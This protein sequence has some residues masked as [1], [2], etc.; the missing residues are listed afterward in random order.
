MSAVVGERNSPDSTVDETTPNVQPTES[1]DQKINSD[2]ENDKSEN[3]TITP[4]D[5]Q[6]PSNE[7]KSA[8]P[9]DEVELEDVQLGDEDSKVNSDDLN[10]DQNEELERP[11]SSEVEQTKQK[12]EQSVIDD[13]KKEERNDDR[14]NTTSAEAVTLTTQSSRPQLSELGRT[15]TIL[16][17]DETP[18]EVFHRLRKG[19][20]DESLSNKE[21]VD[22][23]FNVLVGGPF[24]LESRFIIESSE[25]IVRML[26]LT[27]DCSPK[28]QAEIWSVFVAI[29]RKSFRNLEACTRVGLISICL[30][31]LPNAN[32]IISDLLIELL[33]VLTNYSITVKETKHFLR[34]LHAQDGV[35]RKNSSKL[36]NVMQEMPKRDGA[37]VFFSFPGK[38]GAG[39]ALPPLAKWPYQNGWTFSTWF[40]MDPLNSVN[41]EKEKPFLFYLGTTKGLGYTCYFMGSCLV[42]C[43]VRGSGKEMTRCIKFELQPRKWHHISLSFVY[44]RWAK[45]EIHCFVDGQ[46]V[47]S[48]ESSWF[49]STNE[50]FDRCFIGCGPEMEASQ[51]FC[52]QLGA[53]YM[54]A[55]AISPA[56]AN[57][58]YCLGPRYQSYYKHD[59]ESELPEDYKRHLFDG[60]LNSNLVFAYC[61]KNCHGQLCLFPNTKLTSTYFIQVPHAVMRDSVEVITTHSIHNSL[62]SVGGIQMLLPLFAQIDM[63]HADKETGTVDYKICSRL[64]SVISL[65][66]S[67][68]T[69]AQQQLYHS[70]GF[71]IIS[72]VLS[73]ASPLHLKA[74]VLEA[75][76]N[77]TRFL[78]TCPVGAPL[79]KQ[80]FEQILLA[81]QLWVRASAEIQVYLYEY[82]SNELFDQV[83]YLLYVRR[84]PTIIQLMHAI[85]TYYWVTPPRLPSTYAVRQRDENEGLRGQ[86]V[87]RIRMA[88]LHLINKLM[89]TQVPGYEEKE[90]KRDEEFQCIFNFI[91]NVNEDDNLYDVLTFTMRQ[92]SDNPAIMVPAFDK[93]KG[94]CVIFKI[95]TSANE[96]IRIP[97]L[98]ILGYFMCR[99]TVKRKNE[100][101]NDLNLLHLL[102]DRL[103]TNSNAL[104][105]ATYN[106]LFE[107]LV[108]RIT[109]NVLFVRHDDLPAESTRFE[110]PSL[111]KVIANLI[112]QSEI[113]DDLMAV[114]KA[115]LE[116]MIRYCRDSRENRRIILQMSVWQEWLI[117]LAHVFP[118]TDAENEITDLVYELFGILL[119]HAIRL[120]Y[121][122]WRVWVD[123]LA[124]A[125][126]KISWEKSR[127]RTRQTQFE[128]EQTESITPNDEASQGS[129]EKAESGKSRTKTPMKSKPSGNAPYRT[130]EFVWSRVHI[131][132]LDDLLTYIEK[133]VETWSDS[134]TAIVDY[135]NNNEN[136]IFVSNTVHVLSQLSDSLIMACGGLLPLLAAA[137][138][139]NS[140]LEIQDATHQDITIREAVGFLT[141]FVELA[142]IFIFISG[143]SFNE[144]EQ[145][146]N[147]PSGGILRQALRLVSTMAVRNI[148]ACRVSLQE[149]GF[150]DTTARHKEKFAAIIEFIS[151]AMESKD[152]SK[153]IS[154]VDRLLQEIDI[155]RLKGIIYRDMEEIRQA[156]FLAL[157]VVYL[158]SVLMVSRYRDILEPP[159]SPSPFFDTN[160]DS[161]AR[162]VSVDSST[163]KTKTSPE[164]QLPQ[165]E[166]KANGVQKSSVEENQKAGSYLPTNEHNSTRPNGTNNDAENNTISSIRFEESVGA[167]PEE[168]KYDEEHLPTI[169]DVKQLDT[170][171]RRTYLTEK[172][173]QA[174]ESVAPLL[175]EIMSDFRSFLQ[176][177]LLGTHGQE[178][179]NDVKVMQTLKNQQ[180]SVIELVMLLCSQEWQTSLQKHA[181]LAFIEL[182]NEGR[183]MAH[184]TRDHILRVANEADFILNRLRAE[185]VGKHEKF[186]SEKD[187]QLLLRRSDSQ[188]SDH[189]ILS[190]RRRNF[191][192]ADKLLE[193]MRNILISPTGVWSDDEKES[194]R[195]WRLDQWEDDSR[196]RKRFVP[197]AYGSTHSDATLKRKVE[198]T[199]KDETSEDDREKMLKELAHQ[200]MST[201][202]KGTQLN[203]ELV[204]ESEINEETEPREPRQERALYSTNGQLIAGIAA[205][206]G[207]ISIAVTE[208]YFDADK[209][210][211]DYKKLDS[212]CLKYCDYL[213]GRWMFHEIR[214]I[215]L[216]RY[217]LQ[218]VALELFLASRTAIMFAFPNQEIVKK[219]VEYLPRVGVGVKYGLP[220]NRKT[221][222][223]LPRQLFKHSD[224]PEKWQ[225]REI[226]NFDYLMFLNTIAG[227][228][229]NDLNQYPIFPWVLSNYESDSLD[230]SEAS[231]F[232][233]LSK[234]VGALSEARRKNFQERFNN[235]DDESVPAFHYGTHYS[236][237]SFT[238]N[239][240]FRLEPFTTYFLNLQ[241]GKF[242]HP[243]RLFNSM[244]EAWDGCQR[245]SHNVKELVPELFYLPEMFYNQNGYDLGKRTD[246]TIVSDV[247]L[248][249]WAKSPEH[250]VALHRQALESD[251][252]SCQLNQW[253]DLIF[254]Y[255]QRGPEAVRATNVF[256]YLTYEGAVNLDSIEPPSLR[257]SIE[258][259]ILNFGQTPVQLMTDPHPPRHSIMNLTP[260][261]FQTF[262]DDLC[263]LM[264]FISN[265]A[266]VHISANTYPQLQTPTVVSISQ[267][268]VFALNRWNCN[269]NQ[270][271]SQP[272]SALGSSIT[273]EKQ[274]ETNP[275]ADLP[276]TV[277]PLLAV[278][279]PSQPPPKRHLGDAFD[280]K[281]YVNWSNFVTT[282]DSRSIIACGYPDYSFRVIDTENA[283]VRQAVYGHGDVVT[284]LARSESNLYSDCYV[285]SGSLDCTVVL[286]HFNNQNQMIIGE[287]NT[288]GETPSPRAIL[289]GHDAEITAICVSA[290]HG[291]VISG[292]KDGT[293]LMHTTM[294]DL[295]RRV[296][297]PDLAKLKTK[298]DDCLPSITNILFNREGFM[299]IFYGRDCIA[300]I[301]TAGRQLSKPVRLTNE[302]IL[303]AALSRDGEN[304]VIGTDQGAI[305]VYKFFPMQKLYTFPKTDSAI[306]CIAISTNQRMILG[307]LESGAVV[308]FNVD[309]NKWHY[310][311]SKRRY[312][313]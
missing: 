213:H 28:L 306:R 159:T 179:M 243:D 18:D 302:Q 259:Q 161:S 95:I 105:M 287:Y 139:P 277:D 104:T 76:I 86:S 291:L 59:A 295:L 84:T 278:G 283:T 258:Q 211:P 14:M 216:R 89:F 63:P 247:V 101:I 260:M 125:H 35:W 148:L 142:D 267:N 276:L 209:D 269:Y 27:D 207:K 149:R 240:L 170:G 42:L 120:E 119:Y 137:T 78:N 218:Y 15:T 23:V 292:S 74:E 296:Q 208:F 17:S 193:K 130:P 194:Q 174:L 237:Q 153:G 72:H 68:S 313:H 304:V 99:S 203:N 134:T 223:M 229:Y 151:N 227:R 91:A 112:T 205:I 270:S 288:P 225:R 67:T 176:K 77:I 69:I 53:I 37:D 121:G 54:F 261:M 232:R 96:L 175:R 79:L 144:L 185:D 100:S 293:V 16:S 241:A 158:L 7:E 103:L 312:G 26:D 70:E 1:V 183:L 275:H 115:F 109:P 303:C 117:S 262:N 51:S 238:L 39:I 251:L 178:I 34:A 307:G 56:Q 80:L 201:A 234:P 187:E 233:D 235:W 257:E 122:G 97:A 147:M 49:V 297:S 155:Q 6:E 20:Q 127:I 110:N 52:G 172:L 124:I 93:K 30:D 202:Q 85:K 166:N 71:V 21:V 22:S 160:S 256:Y 55:Q 265:S 162:R 210:H 145:E 75:F 186:D 13:E 143:I 298:D 102:A 311:Y 236:T 212:E 12:V 279:N 264:K 268:L 25:N 246:G 118:E 282:V 191:D 5:N 58:I 19:L 98:K 83:S 192:V 281:L 131:R 301:T 150:S 217:K 221:S 286:W 65:L 249:K 113:S 189:L 253:I 173:K 305:M 248:P 226:S 111:L 82:L 168:E 2:H 224:M 245:D 188:N 50:Y 141:R 289:T 222:L 88:I 9:F 45:S 157:S 177:T 116:D 138:S 181:G 47:E 300:T 164:L 123:T 285:A 263:M 94:I 126:S 10:V 156:Q 242:D 197:N 231:N 57:A 228:T 252:V 114:K 167:I 133:V 8:N 32:N 38:P 24:D 199:E 106:A 60:R 220:Q 92:L 219:V 200:M 299:A 41:F 33:S 190:A 215:F 310:E 254:G 128:F 196:R 108:E 132:L 135:V 204:D 48:I 239:W 184:A 280:Q 180:G 152:P 31:K 206:P 81:P 308:V 43:C 46:L 154:N 90:M 36:L 274:N 61:P 198:V 169:H 87:V 140:E 64:L 62:N 136:Q 4:V 294:G 273:T 29:V 165:S 73:N 244:S 195:F 214:A 290:E 66:L 163:S 182:V 271:N 129:N 146:K 44:S 309:F 266:V 250:F 171:A 11:H 3:S 40:R 107:L 230:L 255:K 272:S 284:C